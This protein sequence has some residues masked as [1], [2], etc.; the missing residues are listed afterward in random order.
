MGY[1]FNGYCKGYHGSYYGS[2]RQRKF[3]DIWKEADKFLEEYKAS[4]LYAANNK[5]S[6]DGI[7]TIYYL[8][9]SNYGGSTI[10]S[11]NEQQFKYQIFTTIYQYGPTWEQKID[12]QNKIRNLTEEELEMGTLTVYNK[13]LNPGSKPAAVAGTTSPDVL[14]YINEQNSSYAKKNKLS[15]Y[16]EQYSMLDD[17]VTGEFCTK[18][19][20]FFLQIVLP[21]RPLYYDNGV[22]EDYIEE[23]YEYDEEEEQ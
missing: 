15:K 1:D 22:S 14:Q 9:Y 23:E 10:A 2:Y 21:E 6:D 4:G 3:S 12:L 13:A 18:F 17:D 11:S 5:V 19:K 20:K 8:L 16:L 7:T